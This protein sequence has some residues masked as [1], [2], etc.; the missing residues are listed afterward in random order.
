MSVNKSI[1]EKFIIESAD[2]ERTADISAGVLAFTYFENIFSP[3]ITAKVIVTN[4]GGTIKGKDGVLQSIYNGLPLRGGERVI[5]KIAGNSKVN[6][7]LD[8]S[9][10]SENYF[11]VASITNVLIDEGSETFTLNLVSREAITNETVRV[12]KKFPTSQKISDS[13]KDILK[14]YLQSEDKIGK[15]DETQNP[16]GFIGNMKK[17][18]TIITWLASKSVSGKSES[19][20]EDS[21]AGFVFYE[22]QNGFNFRSLDELME[23]KPYG[24]DFTYSPGVISSDDPKKD[25]KILQYGIDR[26]QDLIA[27]LE[28][29][30]YSS[31]RYYINPVSFVPSISVFNSNNYVEKLSNLGDQTISLPK[32]DERSNKT[33]GDLP[34]RIFV[35]MLDVGTIEE[36]ASD[37]GWNDPVKRNAD[38]AKI[39][40]QS[41]MRYNQLH[42]QVVDITIPMNTNLSAGDLIKCSFPQIS[43]KK[44]R[45][46]DRETSG[47]YMIKELAHFF[48]SK[49]SFT[50]LKVIRDTFGKK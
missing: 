4:T 15:I 40:A 14:E 35:G 22:T 8:F 37:E 16:Y 39:H 5:I 41:M 44:R 27:K 38:P 11:H 30:A 46:P 34:S 7:G 29:G 28:R 23:Q 3:F 19:N 1:Y 10:N 42:T 20:K 33:L 24:K 21:S 12:G 36:D 49:G 2:Q 45:E 25:F 6:K 32:I 9:K 13:V 47:L 17:P 43:N 50:K 18:F 48:D 26:N 31:Q